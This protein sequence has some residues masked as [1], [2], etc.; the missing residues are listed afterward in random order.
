MHPAPCPREM[1]PLTPNRTAARCL[2]PA[3]DDEIGQ[4]VL[5]RVWFLSLDLTL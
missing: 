3:L 2:F 1:R 5:F 4:R